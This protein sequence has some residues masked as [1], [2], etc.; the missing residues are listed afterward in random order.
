M[1]NKKG[2]TL[3]ELLAVVAILALLAVIAT[4]AVMKVQ[5]SIKENM[6]NAKAKTI[7]EAAIMGAERFEDDWG[8]DRTPET[9]NKIAVFVVVRSGLYDSENNKKDQD[10]LVTNPINNENM[11]KCVLTLNYKNNRWHAKITETNNYCNSYNSSTDK[12]SIT[13]NKTVCPEYPK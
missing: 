5:Q 10:A 8:L 2:F 1:E 13:T 7:V 6:Y 3:I 12:C 9:D 11:A 4:P